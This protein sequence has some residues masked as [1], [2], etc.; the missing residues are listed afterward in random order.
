MS[1]RRGEREG[2]PRRR[3]PEGE[4]DRIQDA[5]RRLERAA[6]DLSTSASDRAAEYLESTAERLSLQTESRSRGDRG[7]A[8][9]WPWSGRPRTA[10]LCRDK[11]NGKILG[12][13]AGIANYYGIENWVVRCI[14]LTGL[15][16]L[17]SVTLV[18][19]FVAALVMD[20]APG[21]QE[22]RHKRRE[23]SRGTRRRQHRA[24]ADAT[25][26]PWIPGQRLRDV[27]ADF[28]QFELR[29]RRM[30]AFVTSGQFELHR[31]LNKIAK[32]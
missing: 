27:R 23:P 30:E 29:L 19:Y 24:E 5:I 18:G 17:T 14:A 26:R 20:K 11:E 21:R 12:V 16:F 1:N 7:D 28:D 13:C 9:P 4:E 22:R 2:E 10:R 8:P 31:E 15:I 3:S 6:K 32:T 25:E